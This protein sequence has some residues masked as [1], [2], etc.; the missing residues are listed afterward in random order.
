M[1]NNQ[2]S[3]PALRGAAQLLATL[4]YLIGYRPDHSLVL[5]LTLLEDARR[6]GSVGSRSARVAMTVRVDLPP[7]GGG[8]ELVAALVEP[9][10]RAI[11]GSRSGSVVGNGSEKGRCGPTIA[12]LHAFALDVDD[13]V[14]R[15]LLA[16]L[17]SKLSPVAVV[18]HDYFVVHGERY[19]PLV[20][21]GVSDDRSDDDRS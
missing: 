13:V 6:P 18:V 19:L 20:R 16:Q 9:V 7:P 4:P 8:A 5:V 10:R 2:T 3:A 1:T 21:N 17:H 14:A 12:L 11:S 15:E